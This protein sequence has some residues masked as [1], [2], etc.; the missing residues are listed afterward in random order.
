MRAPVWSQQRHAAYFTSAQVFPLNAGQGQGRE[1][2][3]PIWHKAD[4]LPH[5]PRGANDLPL[6]LQKG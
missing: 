6:Y 3:A 5:S 1:Y 2:L 4:A